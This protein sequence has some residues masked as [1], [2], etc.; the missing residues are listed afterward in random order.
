MSTALCRLQPSLGGFNR[1]GDPQEV[2][3]QDWLTLSL[4]LR[5]GA[6]RACPTLQAA[7]RGS[8]VLHHPNLTG[9]VVTLNVLLAPHLVSP[10]ANLTG[11]MLLISDFSQICTA[12]LA[13][14][15]FKTGQTLHVPR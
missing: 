8:V 12:S 6:T 2:C 10:Q 13:A 1:V 14:A 7:C 3:R 11:F 4:G 9:A 15:H 5:R